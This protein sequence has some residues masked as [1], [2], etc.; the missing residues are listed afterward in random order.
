MSIFGGTGTGIV[1]PAAMKAA[2]IILAAFVFPLGLVATVI[3][4]LARD[5]FGATGLG[6]FATSRLAVGLTLI[7]A[8]L[9]ETSHALGLYRL[10]FGLPVLALAL[11]AFS[12]KPMI[13]LLRLGSAARTFLG[14]AYEFTV[15]TAVERVGGGLAFLLEDIGQEQ[16]LPVFRGG[17]ALEGNL[18]DQLERIQTAGVRPQL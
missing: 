14:G 6:L 9:G 4:F 2:G 13:G 1:S 12:A 11:P 16:K 18:H 17:A 15:S 10:F 7:T 5:T 3:A 8:K